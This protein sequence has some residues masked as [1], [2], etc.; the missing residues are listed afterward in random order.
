M[1]V[2]FDEGRKEH[3]LT[4]RLGVSRGTVYDMRKQH[5]QKGPSSRS[6]PGR[7]P[8]WASDDPGS[9]GG[10]QDHN[11]GLQSPAFWPEP[12]DPPADC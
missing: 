12:L 3:E 6:T 8:E 11:D 4:K 1:L 10:S 5:Q 7:A 9:S 2:L